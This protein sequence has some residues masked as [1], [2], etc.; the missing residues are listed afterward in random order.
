MPGDVVR[1]FVAMPFGPGSTTFWEKM[2]EGA[3]RLE[4]LDLRRFNSQAVE[5]HTLFESIT[6]QIHGCDFLIADLTPQGEGFNRNVL[7]EA[8]IALGAGKPVHVV[9]QVAEYDD[10]DKAA[11]TASDWRNS[12]VH[13]FPP[14][15]SDWADKF[16][17][18]FAKILS[19]LDRPAL[20]KKERPRQSESQQ[21]L[22][23][24]KLVP[25][26]RRRCIELYA[27][28]TWRCGKLLRDNL[29]RRQTFLLHS[30]ANPDLRVRVGVLLDRWERHGT[31][32]WI[33]VQR[34]GADQEQEVPVILPGSS[35]YDVSTADAVEAFVTELDRVLTDLSGGE[36]RRPADLAR[37][38]ERWDEYLQRLV[39][40]CEEQEA[41]H[42]KGRGG[43]NRYLDW[44]LEMDVRGAEFTLGIGMRLL[45]WA[46]RGETPCWIEVR[47]NRQGDLLQRLDL[48]PRR[49]RLEAIQE[50]DRWLVPVALLE[51]FDQF[52][53][54]LRRVLRVIV[55]R[56]QACSK[57]RPADV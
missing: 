38:L 33:I 14:P 43:W 54:S 53:A 40:V 11:D 47:A 12:N 10:W 44:L 51:N 52:A 15:S 17:D 9:A 25:N 6:R 29:P 48:S 23:L 18:L 41:L 1:G 35:I 34:K 7:T 57:G 36:L 55:E 16:E 5:D 19:G 45:L 42:L 2:K 26:L 21:L 49:L 46:E 3:D 22:W 24:M 50:P 39:A 30:A 37:Q 56:C 8:G 20:R 27:A 32:L 4:D 13:L 31:P 28:T